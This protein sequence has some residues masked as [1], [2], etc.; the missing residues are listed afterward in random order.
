MVLVI[1]EGEK[2]WQKVTYTF[3]NFHEKPRVKCAI[4][5]NPPRLKLS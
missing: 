5:W 1:Q 3:I 2:D 4:T